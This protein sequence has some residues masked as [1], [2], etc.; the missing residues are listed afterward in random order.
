MKQKRATA[1][2]CKTQ[3]ALL[4][5]YQIYDVNLVA[6]K[7]EKAAYNCLDDDVKALFFSC[8]FVTGNHINSVLILQNGRE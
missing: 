2:K 5:H 8:F 3:N 7:V 6:D 1:A 4:K